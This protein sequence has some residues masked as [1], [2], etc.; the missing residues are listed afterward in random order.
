M[1][2]VWMMRGD[3]RRGVT[4]LVAGVIACGAT[5][6]GQG[7]PIPVVNHSFEA[8]FA[9]PN[10]FPVLIPQG[11]TLVDPNGILDQTLD[12]VGVLHPS[13]GT[14]FDDE[15]PDGDNVA[16][17]F[18]SGDV[19]G[20]VVGLRQNVPAVLAPHTRYTLRV[21][22][23]DIESGVGAPPFNVFFDLDGFPGY[24]VQLLAGGEVI[25][26]DDNTLAAV[27]VDGQFLT[28]TVVLD[29]GAA[30]PRLGQQLGIRMI[31]LNIPG[32]AEEPG[33]EVD[34][35]NVRLDAT[36]IPPVC[37]GDL[38]GDGQVDT[39][40]LVSLLAVF[41]QTVPAGAGADI[42]GDGVVNTA[43]LTS[44]LARFGQGCPN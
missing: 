14:F 1:R 44:L 43:D 9:A 24:Q 18:L 5:A 7:A 31:N 16:L 37:T 21:E 34:F 22:V 33:I 20:G 17:V 41:G 6:V 26:Q 42:T 28:S 23:G 38:N 36:P 12:A 30:H 11:W 15:A 2:S 8:N 3:G 29:V 4:G 39:A 35:D 10:S 40:D 19:G 25:A 13:G 27:L 32:T